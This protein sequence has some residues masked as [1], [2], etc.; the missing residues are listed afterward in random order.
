MGCQTVP[1]WK[2]FSGRLATVAKDSFRTFFSNLCHGPFFLSLVVAIQYDVFCFS[3]ALLLI[4]PPR[5]PKQ[6][7]VEGSVA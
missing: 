6:Q 1:F 5:L 4:D 7:K 3:W 2:R